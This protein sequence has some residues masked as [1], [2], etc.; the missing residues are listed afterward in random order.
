MK[1]LCLEVK[2]IKDLALGLTEYMNHWY[3]QKPPH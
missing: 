1:R 2:A 3:L